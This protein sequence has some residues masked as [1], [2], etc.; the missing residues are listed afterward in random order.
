MAPDTYPASAKLGGQ[1]INSQLI[2]MEAADLG[3]HEGIALDVQ[4]YVSEGSG[5]NVFIVRRGELFTPPLASSILDGITRRCVITLAE[6]MG[7]TVHQET[8]P[9]ELLYVADELFFCGTAVEITPIRSVD[10]IAVG[11]GTRGPVTSQLMDAFF[12]IVTGKAVDRHRWLTP[13]D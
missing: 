11:D 9:R 10:G 3:Y 2:A 5:E 6:E 13:V 12:D 4:G 1:Y 7:L 8:I